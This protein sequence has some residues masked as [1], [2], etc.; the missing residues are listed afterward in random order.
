[1]EIEQ[2]INAIPEEHRV[3]WTVRD[4][5]IGVLVL[6]L[7]FVFVL[8]FM[9]LVYVMSWEIDQGL[10][11]S[12][13]EAALII[14]VWW[15]TVRKYKVSWRALGWRGFGAGYIALG[16]G[17][18]IL[19]SGFNF[20]YSSFLLFFDLQM[21]V[22]LTAVFDEL[23]SPWLFLLGGAIIAPLAEEVFF[24][25]FVFAGLRQRYGWQ[26]AALLS[27]ALFAL[28]HFSPLT[29]APLFILGYIWAFLYHASN[30]LWP[31]VLMHMTSNTL[32]LGAAYLISTLN[33]EV[34]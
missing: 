22:D 31:A 17:L 24:R 4:V 25:G 9:A 5:W 30:S 6:A 20:L 27:A 29:F 2:E 16:C 13:L 26:K 28:I 15:L 19:S 3:P 11:V 8:G 18:M 34:L 33:F 23:A 32:A 14:P 1:M 21:Q 7:W 12:V 10:A